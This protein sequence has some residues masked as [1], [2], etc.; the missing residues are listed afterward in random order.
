MSA[1][2]C[3]VW[4]TG[5]SKSSR[6]GRRWEKVA[7][8]RHRRVCGGRRHR[9][10]PLLSVLPV[11]ELW[12]QRQHGLQ[13]QS[14]VKIGSTLIRCMERVFSGGWSRRQPGACIGAETASD[15]L[16]PHSAPYLQNIQGAVALGVN[17]A[18]L[19]RLLEGGG[20]ACCRPASIVLRR[21]GGQRA[22]GKRHIQLTVAAAH[23]GERTP[24]TPCILCIRKLQVLAVFLSPNP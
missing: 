9:P 13:S 7:H 15:P 8:L 24:L 22:A 16:P 18:R 3:W 19:L 10:V 4:R 11:R 12:R 20:A 21:Q 1:A 14:K 5:C 2:G 6:S 17:V 23:K